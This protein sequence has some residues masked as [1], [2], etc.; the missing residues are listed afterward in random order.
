M[1]VCIAAICR[2][3]ENQYIIIG[4]SD[5]KV[6]AGDIQFEPPIQKI[7][8]FSSHIIALTAGDALAQKE[9][10]DYTYCIAQGSWESRCE[11]LLW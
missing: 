5:R 3:S 9:V 8:H 1:T 10:C 11:R 7:Y 2:T 6:T 4:A